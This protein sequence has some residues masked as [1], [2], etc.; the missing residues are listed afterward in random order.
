MGDVKGRI[1]CMYCGRTLITIIILIPWPH[2]AEQDV[3]GHRQPVGP[4]PLAFDSK[5]YPHPS[6]QHLQD[7]HG[8]DAAFQVVEMVQMHAQLQTPRAPQQRIHD[9]G[10][11]IEF[12]CVEKA[13]P[14]EAPGILRAVALAGAGEEGQVPILCHVPVEAVPGVEHDGGEPQAEE[15]CFRDAK[16]GGVGGA[17]EG[18]EE[19]YGEGGAVLEGVCE[20]L[21][22]PAGGAVNNTGALVGGAYAVVFGD[23]LAEAYGGGYADDKGNPEGAA[24]AA[25][26]RAGGGVRRRKSHAQGDEEVAEDFCI[27]R[28]RVGKQDVAEFSVLGLSNAANGDALEGC[29]GAGAAGARDKG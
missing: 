29:E 23:A 16:R 10:S 14:T 17:L 15:S 6:P 27:A 24:A 2:I 20:V 21:A 8:E 22:A 13:M 9:N 25:V 26:G 4:H 12:F 1:D 5:E 28:Q 11:I 18:G 7:L 19:D 3:V